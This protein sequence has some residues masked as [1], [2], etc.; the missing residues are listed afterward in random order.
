[1][2]G[3]RILPRALR[4]LSAEQ[5]LT[6]VTLMVATF[7]QLDTV[8][9]A[10]ILDRP[11]E[12]AQVAGERSESQQRRAAVEVKTEAFLNAIISPVMSVIGNAPLRMVTG[13]LGLLLERNDIHK[14]V[15]SKVRLALPSFLPIRY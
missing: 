5:T 13:M 10:P 9:E 11:V 8:R 4:H 12:E 3:K 6:L 7:D 1:M 14:V 2:K 15:K